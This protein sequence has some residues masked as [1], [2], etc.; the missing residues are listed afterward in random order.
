MNEGEDEVEEGE[1]ESESD[2]DEDEGDEES[3]E[4]VS[5]GPRDNRPFILLED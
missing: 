4:G 3:Y 5:G 2:G 1:R